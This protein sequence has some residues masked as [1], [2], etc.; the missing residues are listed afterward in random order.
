MESGKAYSMDLRKRVMDAVCE[1]K[2]KLFEIAERFKVNVKTI[3]KWRKIFNATGSIGPKKR[4][5]QN[6]RRKITDI[7]KFKLFVKENNNSTLKQIA[8]AWG[9]VSATTIRDTLRRIKFTF[10]KKHSDTKNVMKKSENN[11]GKKLQKW[12]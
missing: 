7:E 11:S 8:V 1:G 3:Y 5:Q 2:L 4:T 6:S 12:I 10:K 9:N